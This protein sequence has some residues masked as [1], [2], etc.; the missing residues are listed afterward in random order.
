MITK[1]NWVRVTTD[2]CVSSLP[3]SPLFSAAMLTEHKLRIYAGFDSFVEIFFIHQEPALA[4]SPRRTGRDERHHIVRLIITSISLAPSLGPIAIYDA[5]IDEIGVYLGL[6][7]RKA[8]CRVLLKYIHLLL[9]T[10]R[11]LKHAISFYST[12]LA[13][14]YSTY[15]SGAPYIST[16]GTYAPPVENHSRNTF[17]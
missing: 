5:G 8:E 3:S 9:L 14:P 15:P 4:F 6:G 11:S 2:K 10:L 7:A 17:S 12:Q 1:Y 13:S 16:H